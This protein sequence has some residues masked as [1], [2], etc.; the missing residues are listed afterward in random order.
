MTAESE[1]ELTQDDKRATLENDISVR[2]ATF[3]AFSVAEADTPRGR[4]TAIEK[5]SVIGVGPPSYPK[6]PDWTVDPV[7]TEP[8]LG[9]DV[10]EM[11][12]TGEVF[13]VRR[14]LEAKAVPPLA[15]LLSPQGFLAARQQLRRTPHRSM[16]SAPSRHFSRR[17]RG[18]TMT[19]RDFAK[20]IWPNLPSSGRS[21]LSPQQRPSDLARAMYPK[22]SPAPPPKVRTALNNIRTTQAARYGAGYESYQTALRWRR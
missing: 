14:S 19:L 15:L 11:Q 21:A 17:T 8:N 5:A 9:F 1:R 6:G 3:H 16:L 4:Y 13:E 22:L 10:K 2:P 18:T 12:P 7:G 20:S